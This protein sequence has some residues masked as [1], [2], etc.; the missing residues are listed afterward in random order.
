MRVWVWVWGGLFKV[1]PLMGVI[2]ES[3]FDNTWSQYTS[4]QRHG[5]IMNL[6]KEWNEVVL[7][8][9]EGVRQCAKLRTSL[10]IPRLTSLPLMD[11]SL[12]L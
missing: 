2:L 3:C 8:E 7:I 11:A 12:I 6:I 10:S 4:F 5:I 1:Q 9:K